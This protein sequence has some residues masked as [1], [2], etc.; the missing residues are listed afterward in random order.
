[1]GVKDEPQKAAVVSPFIKSFAGS[2]GG[3]AE[4]GCLQPIDTIKTRLQLDKAK[5]YKGIVDCGKQIIRDEGT[6]S[7]WKGLTPFA[8]HLT[9]KYALRMGTNAFYQ[10]LLRDK[11]GKLSDIRRMG[12]GFAAGITE[13]LVIVTPFEVVK[14][15]LQQQRGLSKELLKYRGPVHTATTIFREEGLLGLWSGAAPTVM[16]NGTNQM[17]LFWAKNNFDGL[18]FGK[19]EGDGRVLLPWQSMLSG[20]SAACLGPIATGPFDVIKTRLMAQQKSDGP[21]R[22][23]GLLDALVKIP[24]EEGFLAFYKGL[25]PRLLRIPPGQAIV[26]AVSDQIVGYFE[27]KQYE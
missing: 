9:L 7:L 19:E 4:A 20:F 16:R 10:S 14:I 24:A 18:F 2:I 13:A 12:A 8:T 21:A 26:W 27:Q 25:L 6:K 17:C 11:D 15:R 1:M 23:K 5:Q 3:I 22:Y